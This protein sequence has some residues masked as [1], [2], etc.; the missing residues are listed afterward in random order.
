MMATGEVS[1]YA[2]KVI[3]LSECYLEG[4]QVMK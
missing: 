3:T 1:Q 2:Q 4:V